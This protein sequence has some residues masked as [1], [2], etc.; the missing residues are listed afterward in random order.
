M[1]RETY[2]SEF[3]WWKSNLSGGQCAELIYI[4][5][6]CI[7]SAGASLTFYLSSQ[8]HIAQKKDV[9]GDVSGRV[10]R[11]ASLTFQFLKYVHRV[12]HL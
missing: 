5:M 9:S 12:P 4:I 2:N 10:V 11:S 7:L 8:S 3:G 1:N 6:Y